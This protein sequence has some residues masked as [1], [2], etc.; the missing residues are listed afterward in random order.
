M[1]YPCLRFCQA[2]SSDPS[3]D[4]F[5]SK[6]SREVVLARGFLRGSRARGCSGVLSE[7]GD[8][9]TEPC[10]EPACPEAS[11][12]PQG[13]AFKW[14]TG[15]PSISWFLQASEENEEELTDGEQGILG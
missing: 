2:Q 6:L 9:A 5:G 11:R 12:E 8:G 10:P 13:G 4:P 15:S 1:L 7:V 3:E 14:M